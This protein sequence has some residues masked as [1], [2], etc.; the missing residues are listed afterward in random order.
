[1]PQH[2]SAVLAMGH[3]AEGRSL[4][5]FIETPLEVAKDVLEQHQG[6]GQ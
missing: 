5:E 4:E 3:R 2:L 1:M 6:N